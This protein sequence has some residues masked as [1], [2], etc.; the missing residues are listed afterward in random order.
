MNLRLL[1]VLLCLIGLGF[2]YYSMGQKELAKQRMAGLEIQ[3]YFR[4]TDGSVWRE[5]LVGVSRDDL[6]KNRDAA[7]QNMAL[8]LLLA[9]IGASVAVA[10]RGQRQSDGVKRGRA[11][12]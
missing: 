7:Q 9:A 11:Q 5:D 1:G 8:G 4:K 12:K 10:S 3:D 2:A 6:E